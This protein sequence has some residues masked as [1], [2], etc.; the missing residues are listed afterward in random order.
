[1]SAAGLVEREREL[2]RVV[3]LVQALAAGRGGVAAVEGAPGIGKTSILTAVRREAAEAGI[4]VLHVRA[5]EGE[6]ARP[7]AAARDACLPFLLALPREERAACL[8]GAAS[9]SLTALG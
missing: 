3:A 6:R 7:F 4:T 2:A 8:E 9:L 5:T 1:M